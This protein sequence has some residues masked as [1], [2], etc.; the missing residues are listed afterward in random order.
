MECSLKGESMRKYT[1]S[2]GS[3]A[4]V[5][6]AIGAVA[7]ST[8]VSS[9]DT[10][11]AGYAEV[12]QSIAD[13][14]AQTYD[15]AFNALDAQNEFTMTL[16]DILLKHGA[17]VVDHWWDGARGHVVVHESAMHRFEDLSSDWP[18]PIEVS[19][20]DD[21]ILSVEQ[22]TSVELPAIRAAREAGAPSSAAAY[23]PEMNTVEVTIFLDPEHQGGKT[24][25]LAKVR[26]NVSTALSDA[27]VAVSVEAMDVPSLPQ[28]TAT[29]GGLEYSTCTG[30][31][32][33]NRS[34]QYGILLA[35]HCK[36]RPAK[37][38]T[39]TTVSTV[40]ATNQRDLRFTR[41]SGGTADNFVRIRTFGSTR[42]I[43][44]IGAM[45]TGITL[46]KYGKVTG[47]DTATI[48]RYQ[49]CFDYVDADEYCGL[50]R[51]NQDIV[52]KGDSGGPWVMNHTAYGVT[53]GEVSTV[54]SLVAS[55][56][57]AYGY[58]GSTVVKTS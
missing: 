27:T 51:A 32:M 29:I 20:A 54:W 33:A 10:S 7:F 37:Y 12:V 35:A 56:L 6:V 45:T 17:D 58:L 14:T 50:W 48:D 15:E 24:G 34:G 3:V 1:N 4:L 55:A 49:G 28:T 26:S 5:A 8:G 11:S 16:A 43:L 42:E 52:N 36:T 18:A 31:F 25:L 44:G 41:L 30:G 46:E 39:D 23:R 22:R 19:S 38:G 2:L 13:Q 53:S 47:D 57:D 9:S 21:S 40:V